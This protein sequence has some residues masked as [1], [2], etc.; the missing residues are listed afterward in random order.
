MKAKEKTKNPPAKRRTKSP[1]YKL[2]KSLMVQLSPYIRAAL[3]EYGDKNMMDAGKV[4][5]E[6]IALM[7]VHNR[8]FDTICTAREQ[9][10][11]AEYAN[12]VAVLGAVIATTPATLP[13]AD[14]LVEF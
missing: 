14:V 4:V 3:D 1:V 9:A 2:S 7:R 11:L 10:A 13:V 8:A 5:R 6:A 12:G